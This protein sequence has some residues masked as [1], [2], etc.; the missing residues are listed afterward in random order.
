[1]NISISELGN[2]GEFVSG[3]VVVVSL[4]YLAV[5]VKAS[6]AATRFDSYVRAI[7]IITEHQKLLVDPE[8]GKIWL[9]GLAD[10]E[11]LIAEERLG[12]YQLMYILMNAYELRVIGPEDATQNETLIA[13]LVENPGFIRWWKQARESYSD[14]F[15]DFVD[16]HIAAR[17]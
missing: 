1:M 3:V 8:V 5:Q 14:R 15:R 2:I 4:V 16:E 12:F 13:A 7:S 6:T 10:P 17:N 11:S 9:R